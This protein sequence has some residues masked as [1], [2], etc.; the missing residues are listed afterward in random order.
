MIADLLPLR[1]GDIGVAAVDT[2][3]PPGG[4]Q[5]AHGSELL[6]IA[7]RQRAEAQRINQLKD[8]GVRA[9][10]ECQG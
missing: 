8:G 5:D 10:A 4:V 7:D 9:G 1:V 3:V 2:A 6:R